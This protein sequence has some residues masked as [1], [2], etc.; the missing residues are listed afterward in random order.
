MDETTFEDTMSDLGESSTAATADTSTVLSRN[1]DPWTLALRSETEYPL[2]LDELVDLNRAEARSHGFPST[3]GTL[4]TTVLSSQ[5]ESSITKPTSAGTSYIVD[6][7]TGKS[8]G[9]IV[10]GYTCKGKG[11]IV[12]TYASSLSA[13]HGSGS[14]AE[15][16]QDHVLLGVGD[17]FEGNTLRGAAR[18]RKRPRAER[19]LRPKKVPLVIH[20]DGPLHV[21]S[22][23]DLDPVIKHTSRC[24]KE[25]KYL[26]TRRMKKSGDMF[27]DDEERVSPSEE[28]NPAGRFSR[29]RL[30][31]IIGLCVFIALTFALSVFAAHHTGKGRLACT[32]GIIFSATILISMCTVLGM[33]LARRALQEAL[34]AGLLE[35]VVGFALVIE[36]RDFMEH[37]H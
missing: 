4:T 2:S 28:R 27:A 13:T 31:A 18:A 21:F 37:V 3:V 22:E 14:E 35:F 1:D 12:K 6:G 11:K 15:A 5:K 23:E 16:E 17:Q 19:I 9:K 26:R 33:V 8:K 30:S 29:G 32:K 34:L 25:M 7:Y 20:Y 36:I 10:D 24:S